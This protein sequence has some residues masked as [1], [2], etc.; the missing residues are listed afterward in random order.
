MTD[1]LPWP[2]IATTT[3][4]ALLNDIWVD[5][6]EDVL[7]ASS[8]VIEGGIGRQTELDL[9]VPSSLS[10]VLRNND[11]RYTPDNLSSSLSPYW[12]TGVQIRWTETIG[13]RSFRFPDMFLEIPETALTTFTDISDESHNDLVVNVSCVDLLTKLNRA[14]RF[15]SNL[16]AYIKGVGG[17]TLKA[18]WPCNEASLPFSSIVNATTNPRMVN[19]QLISSL[20]VPGQSAAIEPQAGTMPP[21]E[22]VPAARI[23]YLADANGVVTQSAALRANYTGIPGSLSLDPGEVM[24]LVTWVRLDDL[25]TDPFALVARLTETPADTQFLSIYSS[26]G[27]WTADVF[28]GSLSASAILSGAGVTAAV[29]YPVA[30]RYGYTPNVFELWVGPVVTVGSL[31]GSAPS[32]SELENIQSSTEFQGT[33]GHCQVYVG[34]AEDFTHADLLAQMDVAQNGFYNQ[35]VDARIRAIANYAGIPDAQLDL[36]ESDSVMPTAA[37]ANQQPGALAT[38]AATTGGGILFTRD[39]ELVYQDRKHRFNL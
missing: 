29:P 27:T 7:Q 19:D 24:T 10:F 4:D 14:P 11:G 17:S 16:A 8:R 35:T 32:T 23:T 25:A 21:G 39:S 38:A 15:S 36:E 2:Q 13:A 28:G 26:A 30:I 18:Y 3:V 34:A 12:K 1:F 6:T 5:I 9:V 33:W 20:A 37:W 31:T 22:D